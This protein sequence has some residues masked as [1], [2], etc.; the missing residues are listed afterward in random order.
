MRLTQLFIF[1]FLTTQTFAQ[2]YEVEEVRLI[3]HI[4]P[5]HGINEKSDDFSPLIIGDQI[6]FTS[7]REYNKHNVGE[8][9]WDKHAYL[10]VFKGKIESHD[11]GSISIDNIRLFSNRIK[12]NN[13]TGPISF[14]PSGDTLFYTQ[15][16]P[17]SSP[18]GAY[19]AQLF[20]AVNK[21]G[22]WTQRKQ[23]PFSNGKNSF[24]H[25]CYDPIQ[26]RLYFAS[27]LPDGKGKK[28]IYYSELK[29]G[30]WSDPVNMTTINT[31][32][33]EKFP[34]VING[35]IFFS[36]DRENGEGS[37]D[38]YYS[39]QSSS[40]Y[41]IKLEGLNSSF[42]DFG[43]TILPDL[44]AGY[45]SSNRNGNDDILYFTL[46]KKITVKNQ[47]SGSFTFKSIK[48]TV[49]NLLVQL[50]DGQGEFIYEQRTDKN[51]YF[52]FEDIQLDSNFTVK[53]NGSRKD[54]LVLDFYDAS[55]ETIAT[56][57]LD[58]DGSF[59]YKKLLYDHGGVINF[60]PDDMVN[61]KKKYAVLSGKMVMEN[62]PNTALSNTVIN[63]V[64][65][66]ENVIFTTT[67]DRLGNFEF[68][69]IG[70]TKNYYIQVPQCSDELIMYIYHSSNDI[71]TQ[72]KCNGRDK[73][74]YRLLKANN[75][76]RL[77]L[78]STSEEEIFMM[79]NTE[80][81][82]QF[83]MVGPGHV[84]PSSKCR[85]RVYNDE[86]QL[87]GRT[88]IDSLGHFTFNNLSNERTFKFTHEC[89][90][91]LE[92]ILYNRYGKV[93]AKIQKEEDDYYVFRPMGFKSDDAL[94][95]I[96]TD[97]NF[98]I[99]SS[100]VYDVVTVYFNSNETKVLAN[101]LDKL[102]KLYKLLRKYPDLRLS[103]NAYAD[104]IASDEY[105]FDLS[106][107]RGDW[108][109][110]YLVSKGI[111]ENR[112]TVN[113]YGETRLIDPENDAVNRRAELRIYR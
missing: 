58:K 112:F 44:S 20:M 107:K 104:A 18:K 22:K 94:S 62:D 52:L 36:S 93:I 56:F 55:G 3:A 108:I 54:D 95:Y 32:A 81:I 89:N 100:A 99:D 41:P 73:F 47:L 90:D 61:R 29:N 70:L 106:Q 88:T 78:I 45:F 109:V 101:D 97:I 40:K 46:E 103:V 23:L 111:N 64:D 51:G 11:N 110:A 34:F 9:N 66:A 91:E 60:I 4:Q 59:K 25:P 80:I 57:I 72:L 86:G 5:I 77:G 96:D 13:H 102:D 74:L 10:N 82:G 24:G 12:S 28:D 98:N 113:A 27:D 19:G 7:S 39:E 83:E 84:A 14:T 2:S 1:L 105:N 38:I 33:D 63:L 68:G 21:K 37:L 71:F 53:V 17:L 92:L 35:N 6:Y 42:D 8:N 15:V 16:V 69:D 65:S 31:A 75:H 43:V 79:G 49:D 48:G 30:K 87:M 50:Y 26:N 76:N 67:T 85:I